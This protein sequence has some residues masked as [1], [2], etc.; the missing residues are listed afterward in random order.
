M[1]DFID[2]CK[3]GYPISGEDKELHRL[4]KQ[5]SYKPKR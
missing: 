1:K 5:C 4:L 2:F 3:N